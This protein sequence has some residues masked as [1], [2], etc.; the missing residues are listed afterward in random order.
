MHKDGENICVKE[1]SDFTEA[2]DSEKEGLLSSMHQ[3]SFSVES[4]GR[5]CGED[6]E[7]GFVD[8]DHRETDEDNSRYKAIASIFILI[9]VFI[10]LVEIEVT[11][12][13]FS[14]SGDSS[15]G[16]VN[17]YFMIWMARNLYIV[18]GFGA[19]RLLCIFAEDDTIYSFLVW[20]P[21]R[22]TLVT[23][24]PDLTQGQALCSCLRN[25]RSW[26]GRWRP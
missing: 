25:C 14:G 18:F 16:G 17:S 5:K 13:L 10:W 3:A 2:A 1:Y 22:K 8:F 11:R 7:Q 24:L 6:I 21:T 9:V 19:A 4:R 12:N 26:M 15:D 20:Q 23:A